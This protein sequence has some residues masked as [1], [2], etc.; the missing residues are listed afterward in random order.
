MTEDFSYNYCAFVV[1]NSSPSY[2]DLAALLCLQC[3]SDLERLEKLR[4][5]C[6]KLEDT[7]KNC[8]DSLVLA[9]SSP[10]M[11]PSTHA[12]LLF[13]LTEVTN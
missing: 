13:S 6:Q 9:S 3:I 10:P 4:I 8:T 11:P 5:S 1:T 7:F 2:E 12:V